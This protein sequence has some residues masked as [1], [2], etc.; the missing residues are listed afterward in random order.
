VLANGASGVKP[1]GAELAQFANALEGICESLARQILADGEGVT[2]VFE[3]TVRGAASAE[4]ARRAAR[5]VTTSNLVKTAIHGS[6]PNWG[7]I[8]AAAG[9]SGATVDQ[10][11]ASVRIGEVVV[12]AAGEP[13][14][15]DRNAVR[16]V[17]DQAEI[18]IEIDLGLGTDA[19]TAW[20]TDLSAEYVR[21]NA[22][23][24]T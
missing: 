18:P 7:R 23:Y 3:V 19:A 21:I 2:K 17:F 5:T 14:S 1:Q 15:L 11:R 8:L 10:T 6:D 13:R 16:Q 9:R 20:G 12:F 24:T 4:D 22:D